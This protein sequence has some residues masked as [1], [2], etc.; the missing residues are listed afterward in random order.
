MSKKFMQ[1]T[2]LFMY[3]CMMQQL[4]DAAN[5]ME[6]EDRRLKERYMA[7]LRRFLSD[8]GFGS[9]YKRIADILQD[10][11]FDRIPFKN[12]G[13]RDRFYETY[14]RYI[15]LSDRDVDNS[16]TA[17]IY[18]LSTDCMFRTVLDNYIYNPLYEFRSKVK[19]CSSEEIYN[20]YQAARKLC[21][22]ESGLEDE[23]LIEEGIIEDRTVCLILNAMYL[24]EYGLS[25]T[26]EKNTPKKLKYI[27]NSKLQHKTYWYN[28]QTVRIKGRK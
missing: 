1:G 23:D 2:D 8:N 3:E 28:G 27:N 4:P 21:G 7:I 15:K 11:L 14:C 13:H 18:L 16:K 26:E 6:R 24:K 10:F 5:I 9:V 20:I 17:V 22:L 19:G 12:E 25:G